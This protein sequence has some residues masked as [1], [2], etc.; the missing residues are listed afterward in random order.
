MRAVSILRQRLAKS[1][2]Q[3]HA[4]RHAALWRA[5]TGLVV[6]GRLWL[7]GLG[8][9]LPGTARKKHQIKAIDR[10]LG[11]RRLHAEQLDIYRAVTRLLL[12]PYS[13]PVILVDWTP[14]GTK[15]HALVASVPIGGRA[16]PL[17]QEVHPEKNQ[18]KLRL[19]KQFL[20]R[21][22]SLLPE[23]CRPIVVTDAGFRSSWFDAVLKHGWDFVGRVRH[24]SYVS[25]PSGDW[26]LAKT[27][28]SKAGLRARDLGWRLLTRANPQ[29]RRFVIVRK[30]RRPGPKVSK[31]LHS[32]RDEK[33]RRREQEPWLLA[34][35]LE[36]EYSARQI[37]VCYRK[38]MQ[39]EETFRDEK[40]P[41][42]GWSFGYARSRS[43]RRYEV[44]L[45]LATL[46]MLAM[47][48]L[49]QVAEAKGIHRGYQANT[50][51][52]RRVLSF[53]VLAKLLVESGDDKQ[54]PHEAL[55]NQMQELRRLTSE[56]LR[57]ELK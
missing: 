38:R 40:N 31:G 11:N 42:F 53:F 24:R 9:S 36:D 13:R 23:G 5:V 22:H 27:L 39:I 32:A 55:S 8:R 6:G 10:L 18:G 15:H 57:G 41:R 48:V 3:I 26:V 1:L 51:S 46:G 47:V 35:S 52:S 20:R 44:L 43:C 17:Y 19:H 50:I 12:A 2:V 54:V 56:G 25:E 21:F 33:C 30:R 14:V 29:R 34:T 28:H 16:L 4:K 7:T 49:G 37:V 45:L